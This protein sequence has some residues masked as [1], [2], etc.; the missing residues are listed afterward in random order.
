MLSPRLGSGTLGS[1]LGGS[2]ALALCLGGMGGLSAAAIRPRAVASKMVTHIGR[3]VRVLFPAASRLPILL[4]DVSADLLTADTR[5]VLRVSAVSTPA[6]DAVRH[7]DTSSCCT[8][9]EALFSPAPARRRPE[10]P[11]APLSG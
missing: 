11:P 4:I 5:P 3:W 9:G 8:G 6:S 2:G 1:P 7:S 10:K